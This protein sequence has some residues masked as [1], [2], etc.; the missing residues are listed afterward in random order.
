L[1]RNASYDVIFDDDGANEAADVVAITVDRDAPK[2]PRIEV[3]LY[4]L[5][6]AGGEP[7]RRLEDLYVVCGQ[8]QR[9]TSWLANH[10]RRTDLFTHLLSR[11]DQRVQRGAPTRF[12]R[13]DEDLLL[14]IREMSRRADVKLKVYV[15]QP[16]LSKALASNGQLMLLA[17]TERFLSDTYE[18]PFSVMCS[19]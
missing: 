8:A 3:E 2:V 7:G 13:G 12:E 10:G 19:P 4:H 18:I 11:N 16:G 6:Y 1:L 14:Q 9:S 17:V 15:V 5:K